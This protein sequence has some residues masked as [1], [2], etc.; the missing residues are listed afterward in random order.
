MAFKMI[1]RKRYNKIP[2][3]GDIYPMPTTVYIEDT[4]Q[5]LSVLSGQPLGA[6]SPRSGWVD[7]FLD[8]R[9]L[10]DD[11]RGLNQGVVDNRKTKEIFK[12]LLES[13]SWEPT[14]PTQP[15]K[16]SLEAQIEL[17]KILSPPILM[18]STMKST[19]SEIYFLHNPLP[20]NI[21]L[22]N[23]RRSSKANTYSLYLHRWGVGCDAKCAANSTVV[24]SQLFSPFI[25]KSLEPQ[26]TRMSLSSLHEK[27]SDLSIDSQLNVEEMHI[28]VYRLR[29]RGV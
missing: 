9:L 25:T 24:L 4:K 18:Y 2:L 3:Q 11:Q 27:E 13:T 8:R 16:P 21:H 17:Q 7:I 6:T 23:M 28:N 1:K 12:I 29:T 10:Q 22:L 26:I 5:R 14:A 19:I 15:L 20:C